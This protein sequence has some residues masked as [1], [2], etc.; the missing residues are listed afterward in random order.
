MNVSI[1]S[2]IGLA[3]L[4]IVPSAM[5]LTH[6]F[7]KFQDMLNGDL[8]FA[9]P[10]GIGQSP[11]L[12]LAVIG[13]FVCPILIIIGFKTRWF[14]VPPAIT[15]LVAAFVVHSSDPFALKEKALLYVTFFIAIILLGPGKFSIGRK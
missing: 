1:T 6:G 7:P 2:N 8:E 10:I 5:L 14:A 4:R 15:L 9:D 11:S 12:F 13:L 3:L